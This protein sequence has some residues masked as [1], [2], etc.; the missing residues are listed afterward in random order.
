MGL[1]AE[2]KKLSLT[3]CKKILN[4]DGMFYTDEEIIELRDFIYHLTDIV[5]DD[6]EKEKDMKSTKQIEAH[7]KDKP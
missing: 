5:M 3:A 2:N 4:T 1:V 6:L 7:N